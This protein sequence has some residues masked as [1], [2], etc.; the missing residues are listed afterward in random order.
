MREKSYLDLWW[1]FIIVLGMSG[2]FEEFIRLAKTDKKEKFNEANKNSNVSK[3]RYKNICPY[4]DTRVCLSPYP[5]LEGSD[6]IN[7]NYIDSYMYKDNFIATQAPLEGTASDFWRM[8]WEQN[9]EIIV[10]L[11]KETDS[12][13]V[14]VC[15]TFHFFSSFI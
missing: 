5:G 12:G 2:F 11:V 3:N 7:A 1:I 4:D 14:I 9:S 8:T 15:T 10:V 6:Y 13:M